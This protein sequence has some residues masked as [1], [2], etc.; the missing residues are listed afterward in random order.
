[1]SLGAEHRHCNRSRQAI[2]AKGVCTCTTNIMHS[3][4]GL[5]LCQVIIL[6]QTETITARRQWPKRKCAC[7]SSYGSSQWVHLWSKIVHCS[8]VV[9]RD[10][11]TKKGAVWKQSEGVW[12]TTVGSPTWLG[13]TIGVWL[14][15]LS[16]LS[17]D[18]IGDRESGAA[19]SKTFAQIE[20]RKKVWKLESRQ[21]RQKV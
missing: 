5:P 17:Q 20:Q 18:W 6:R 14:C 2:A 15:A 16:A 10:S 11:W 4:G 13:A 9:S 21:Q 12:K 19:A 1:M 7:T 3:H 8:A